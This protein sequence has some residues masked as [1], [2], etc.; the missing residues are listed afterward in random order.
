MK[1]Y[2]IKGSFRGKPVN[3]HTDNLE[4]A[5]EVALNIYGAIYLDNRK[6]MSYSKVKEEKC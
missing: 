2:T 3:A 1:K 4:K 6:I 5:K